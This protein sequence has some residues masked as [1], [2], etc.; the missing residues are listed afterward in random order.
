M[1]SN[2]GCGSTYSWGTQLERV[3]IILNPVAGKGHGARVEPEVRDLLLRERLKFDLVRTEYPGHATSLAERAVHDGFDLIVAAGGDGTTN[4]VVNGL[5]GISHD[6]R[7]F[8]LGVLPVGYGCGFASNVGI[9]S[10]LPAA[11]E[12]LARGQTRPVDMCQVTVDESASIYFSNT[13][14]VGFG[15]IVVQETSKMKRAR[16]FA[17][18]LPAV[19][20]AV[21]R[22]QSPRVTIAIGSEE[23]ALPATMICIANGAREGGGFLCAPDAKPDDGAF[24]MCVV[25]ETSRLNMLMLVPQFITGA[26]TKRRAVT[27]SR[28][29]HISIASEDNLIAHMDGELLCSQAHKLDFDILHHAL[30]VRC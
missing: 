1:G 4:E 10:D 12:R 27:M 9:P 15:G 28:A 26:H 22:S 24:D 7:D 17:P 19:L 8:A 2:P 3:K 6:G 30:K 16:G 14:N 21:F 20:K 29:S 23:M 5:V 11:C 25:R 13:V 18:C